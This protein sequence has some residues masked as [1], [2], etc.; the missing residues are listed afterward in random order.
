MSMK[1][2]MVLAVFLTPVAFT[3]SIIGLATSDRSTRADI[4]ME[5]TSY[6]DYV[7]VRA[8]KSFVFLHIEDEFTAL[9]GARQLSGLLP[10]IGVQTLTMDGRASIRVHVEGWD[11]DRNEAENW[12]KRWCNIDEGGLQRFEMSP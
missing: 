9:A 1:S 2:L 12:F 5:R 3:G 4:V 6:C 7:V 8:G 11:D 10:K